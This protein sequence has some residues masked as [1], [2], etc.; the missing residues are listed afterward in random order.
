VVCAQSLKRSI[1]IEHFV[2]RTVAGAAQVSRHTSSVTSSCFPFNCAG[3]TPARAP[4]CGIVCR[5]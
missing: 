1:R 4:T 2:R 5:C 3:W